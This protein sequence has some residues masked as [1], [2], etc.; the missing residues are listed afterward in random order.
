MVVAYGAKFL[1]NLAFTQPDDVLIH[2]ALTEAEQASREGRPGAVLQH[3]SQSFTINNDSLGGVDIGQY[4]RQNH[5]DI[6]VDFTE[7]RIEGSYA[8]M[9]APASVRLHVLSFDQVFRVPKV[10][11]SFHKESGHDWMGL[12]IPEWRLSGVDVSA[13]TASTFAATGE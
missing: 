2:Q 7:P 10:K 4:V 8:V 1:A 9:E 6:N 11:L 5:P 3:L 12:P 13:S